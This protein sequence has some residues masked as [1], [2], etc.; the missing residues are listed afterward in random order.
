MSLLWRLNARVYTLNTFF[1]ENVNI[2]AS[3]AITK[4]IHWWISLSSWTLWHHEA[5]DATVAS[6][7]YDALSKYRKCC[8]HIFVSLIFTTFDASQERRENLSHVLTTT[9]LSYAVLSW[10]CLLVSYMTRHNYVK[11]ALWCCYNV[12]S[13]KRF[14]NV[15]D[16]VSMALLLR[17]SVTSVTT[18]VSTM[19]RLRDVI[20]AVTINFLWRI[21]VTT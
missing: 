15:T 21:S 4:S 13:I 5:I 10:R 11:I 2:C 17:I 16:V 3:N 7:F 20:D 8:S 6:F 14:V 1:W 12:S 19:T 18:H 9:L